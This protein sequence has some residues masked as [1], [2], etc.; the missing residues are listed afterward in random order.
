MGIPLDQEDIAKIEKIILDRKHAHQV[1]LAGKSP[2]YKAFLDME[3]AA[4]SP[5]TLS[6]MQKE[7]IAAGISIVINCESCME[8]HISQALLS[9]ATENQILEAIEAGIEMGG[10]PATVSSRFALKVLEYHRRKK[11]DSGSVPT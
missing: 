7:L 10:G 9:G 6:T 11:N 1:F 4:F 3:K 2:V 8:W 5:R